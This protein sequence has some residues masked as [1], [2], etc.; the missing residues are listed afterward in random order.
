M[1]M[2]CIAV[3]DEVLALKKIKR[4]ADITDYLLKPIP[5]DRF[6]KAVEKVYSR[7]LKDAQVQYINLKTGT[8]PLQQNTP[9]FTFVK[10]GNKT[11][12]IY[13][14]KILYIE[15]MRDYQQ[16]HTGKQQLQNRI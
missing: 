16:I 1:K 15:G 2:N 5:F 10:L 13:Y 12:K 9:G 11:I 6:V 8:A 4:Y 7:F 3:D 14:N